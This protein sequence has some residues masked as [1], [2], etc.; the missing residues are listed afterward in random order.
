MLAQKVEMVRLAKKR[1]QV[2]RDRIT[3]FDDL[4]AIV[5]GEQTA[6]LREARQLQR[7]Q[8]SGQATV[9]ELAFL[10]GQ[11]DAGDLFDQSAQRFEIL[12]RE[13]ELARVARQPVCQRWRRTGVQVSTFSIVASSRSGLKG[14]TSQPVAP[15]ALPASLRSAVASVVSTSNGTYL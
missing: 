2:G 5:L 8:P 7:A 11:M 12:I 6:I 4:A 9:D 10:L 13:I 1:S 3:E 15:A 14:L